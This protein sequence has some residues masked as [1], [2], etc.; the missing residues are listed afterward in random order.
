MLLFKPNTFTSHT[1]YFDN[2]DAYAPGITSVREALI[3]ANKVFQLSPNP[4]QE[5]LKLENLGDE[6]ILQTSLL[7]LDGKIIQS[8]SE[9]VLPQQILEMKV[10][11]AVAGTYL[12]QVLRA[13]G[14]L[15]V[16]KWVKGK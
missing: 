14:K 6:A 2:L 13:D 10:Q 1:Y 3:D 8:S 9:R 4:G 7:S 12:V 5:L 15:A 16:K 11:A